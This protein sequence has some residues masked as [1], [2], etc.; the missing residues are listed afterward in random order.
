M[1][2]LDLTGLNLKFV[3]AVLLLEGLE[4]NLLGWLFQ[5]LEA[6][7][8]SCLVASSSIFK[9]SNVSSSKLP[10]P[11]LYLSP[12]SVSRVTFPTLFNLSL[13]PLS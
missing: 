3:G 7:Y 4:E 2:K 6:V 9:V 12:F 1:S 5:V 8:I 10:F 13:L 11:H